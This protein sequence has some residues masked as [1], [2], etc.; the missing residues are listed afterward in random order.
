VDMLIWRVAL[1]RQDSGHQ[2]SSRGA[3]MILRIDDVI[4][5]KSGGPAG[6]PGGAGGMPGGMGG[7]DFE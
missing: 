3:V 4:A 1:Q 6:G 7:E 2:L 5:S